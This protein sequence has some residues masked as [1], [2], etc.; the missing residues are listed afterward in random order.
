MVVIVEQLVEW[1]LE[2]ETEV[3]G[4]IP[5]QHHFV[6]HKDQTRARSRAAAVGSQQLT[7]WVMERPR[8]KK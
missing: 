4:E 7:A 6:H 8:L 3:L 2:G 1:R 5:P